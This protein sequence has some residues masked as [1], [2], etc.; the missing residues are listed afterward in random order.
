[1]K[2]KSLYVIVLLLATP[3][4]TTA[5]TDFNSHVDEG[6]MTG[7]S[8]HSKEIGWSIQI[9]E[10]WQVTARNFLAAQDKKGKEAIEKSAG[11]QI[12]MSSVT[13]LVA[14][15]KSLYNSFASTIEPF[16]EEYPGQYQ[17]HSENLYQMLW[18]T[19]TDNK[20]KFDTLL[21]TETIQ[22]LEFNVFEI[23]LYSP[24]GEIVL[25]QLIYNKLYKGYD[26]GVNINSNND[27]DKKVLLTALRQ[28]KFDK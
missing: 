9:P 26:F 18:Q 28:S 6:W 13:H 24:K 2:L 1:M 17:E 27:F 11:V 23:N 8:Y 4:S 12:D 20:M 22:G 5:Q 10:G 25:N 14:F 16:E 7:N 21:R 15:Q 19:F 3:I